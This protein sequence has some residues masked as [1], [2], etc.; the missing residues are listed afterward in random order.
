MAPRPFPP[1]AAGDA[2]A[3]VA[4]L[5]ST[6]LARALVAAARGT[7]ALLVG[8]ALRDAA[9]GRPVGDLDAVVA[10]DGEEIAT[11]L[12]RAL[13]G[14]A[15]RLAPG[16]F[17]AW[18]V[19]APGAEIDL[20]DLE[21]G[22]I[23]A[24]LARRDLTVN[25]LAL[26]LATGALLDPHGALHDLEHR[27]L[28]AVRLATFA[29]DPLRVLRLARFAV[30]LDGFTIDGESAAAARHAAAGLDHVAGE[31]IRDELAAL[32][33]LVRPAAAQAALAEVGAF[34]GLWQGFPPSPAAAR[35]ADAAAEAFLRF[36]AAGRRL[37]TTDAPP[38]G[39]LA[40]EHALR[41]TFTVPAGGRDAALSRL[42]RRL[43]VSRD[44]A[45]S[46]RALAAAAPA[47]PPRGAALARLLWRHGERWQA[48]LAL[49]CALGRPGSAAAWAA[50][51]DEARAEVGRRGAALLSPRPLVGGDE[52]ARLLGVVPGPRLGAALRA[53]VD[54]QV[55][56][57]VTTV[58]EARALLGRI[59]RGGEG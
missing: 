19:A 57:Q 47:V 3:R 37:A 20:W 2:R 18:R 5:A 14:R 32:C 12:A 15:I 34:P 33:A 28:R 8:G 13:D 45:R 48:G 53:L 52:A 54:A 29:E 43:V 55:V 38:A 39:W 22:G 36:E 59:G 17:A 35:G 7:R 51:L 42:E 49:A 44:E 50:A 56:G 31:R 10:R 40:A 16:R 11:R 4:A 21:G 23:D 26:D 24:D 9:L 27:R 46:A 1:I 6:P 41:I 25:A 30:A 58:E